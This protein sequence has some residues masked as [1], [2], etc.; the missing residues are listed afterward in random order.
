M[1]RVN[2]FFFNNCITLCIYCGFC[3][4]LEIYFAKIYCN[5]VYIV[6]YLRLCNCRLGSFSLVVTEIAVVQFC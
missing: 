3:R 2:R 1:Q 5:N 4:F 6:A